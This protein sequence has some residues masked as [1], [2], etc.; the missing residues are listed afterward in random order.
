MAR[1]IEAQTSKSEERTEEKIRKNNENPIRNFE[2][3]TLIS[4][5]RISYL[6]FLV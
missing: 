6:I 1:E 2:F 5:L 4:Y 3:E